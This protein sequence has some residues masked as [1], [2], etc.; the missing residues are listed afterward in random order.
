MLMQLQL[1]VAGAVEGEI[2]N[3]AQVH[4]WVAA[5]LQKIDHCGGELTVR[6][7]DQ[8]EM[9]DLNARYRG[10]HGATN[11][12]S[13]P[14]AADDLPHDL[15]EDILGDVVICAPLVAGEAAFQG[16]AL[17][18]HWAHLVVHGVL[19]LCGY[20][21]QQQAE[22]E[23]METLEQGILANLGIMSPCAAAS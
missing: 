11:V 1:Q 7:V 14:V 9:A 22:A 17:M 16:K 2:P 5:A 23:R 4:A 20:D 21:H 10:K 6:V 12:L 19:H 8:P 18:D 3:R 15:P 13:F